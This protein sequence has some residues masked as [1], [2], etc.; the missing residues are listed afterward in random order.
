MGFSQALVAIVS[1]VLI[2]GGPII[3]IYLYLSFSNKNKA[4]KMETL[5]KVV[6][7]GAEVDPELLKMLDEPSGPTIDLRKGLVWLALGIPLTIALFF[8]NGGEEWE[9]GLFGLI[10]VFIGIAYLIVMKYGHDESK[11]G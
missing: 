1:I 11:T 2:F 8:A 3:A 6:E 9:V 7:H 4:K 5:V 10:P